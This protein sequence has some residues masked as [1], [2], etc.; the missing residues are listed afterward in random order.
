MA[1]IK[2]GM[3]LDIL[4]EYSEKRKFSFNSFD[5]RRLQKF[6][7]ALSAKSMTADQATKAINDECCEFR[8]TAD[9]RREISKKLDR[10]AR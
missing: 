8:L 2:L 6:G 1:K 4:K 9:D 10:L 7:E 3:L 5:E